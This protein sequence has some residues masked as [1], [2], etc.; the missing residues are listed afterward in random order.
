MPKFML[1]KSTYPYLSPALLCVLL[2]CFINVLF[3]EFI[4]RGGP[5]KSLLVILLLVYQMNQCYLD[6]LPGISYGL[7]YHTP[8]DK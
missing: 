7:I 5:L 6:D 1:A 8:F 3:V 2:G 4:F